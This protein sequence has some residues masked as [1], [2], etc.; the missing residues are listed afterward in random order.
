MCQEGTSD[1][2]RMPTTTR[3]SGRTSMQLQ[4]INAVAAAL[5]KG[6][7]TLSLLSE[8][9]EQWIN[10]ISDL[11]AGIPPKLPPWR[12][13]NHQINLIDPNKWINYHLP[14]CPDAL[15]SSCLE[16]MDSLYA[17]M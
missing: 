12:M 17:Y 6:R 1:M 9:R 11:V 16:Q 3:R 15:W 10:K 8:I 5:L 13:I 7:N 4:N 2:T 14:K